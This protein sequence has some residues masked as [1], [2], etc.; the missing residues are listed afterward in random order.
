MSTTLIIVLEAQILSKPVPKNAPKIIPIEESKSSLDSE[1]EAIVYK[2]RNR[3]VMG[4]MGVSNPGLGKNHGLVLGI[5]GRGRKSLLLK[6]Q[7]KD[8]EDVAIGKKLS[9]VGALREA[10]PQEGVPP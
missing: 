3:Q 2:L 5:K 8:L 6:A 7:N 9:I 10:K 1:E 4:P